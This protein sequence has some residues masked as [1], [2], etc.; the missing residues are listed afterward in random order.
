MYLAIKRIFD[1]AVAVFGLVLAMPLLVAVAVLVRLD[2]G[3]PILFKQRRV[4]LHGST[5]EVLKFRTMTSASG[6]DEER[7]SATGRWLRALALDELPQLVN[8]L[9]GVM[10]IVGPRPLLPEYVPL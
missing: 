7:V 10:S 5:F 1:V 3:T 4:G 8:V 9:K 6:T 2:V